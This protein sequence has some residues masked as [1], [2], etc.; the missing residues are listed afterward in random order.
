MFI[1]S[2]SSVFV[3]EKCPI[4]IMNCKRACIWGDSC[5]SASRLSDTFVQTQAVLSNRSSSSRPGMSRPV[6]VR[7]ATSSSRPDLSKTKRLPGT[8]SVMQPGLA[9]FGCTAEDAQ[10]HGKKPTN[11]IVRWRKFLFHQGC[12]GDGRDTVFQLRKP[13]PATNVTFQFLRF[14]CLREILLS[15]LLGRMGTRINRGHSSLSRTNRGYFICV[16][17]V[18]WMGLGLP[19]HTLFN[20]QSTRGFS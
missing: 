9:D 15:L 1:L 17:N 7:V 20:C 14:C 2:A 19:I 8:S 3:P 4:S 12:T 10:S 5:I 13:S 16:V 6:Q 18:L 11:H